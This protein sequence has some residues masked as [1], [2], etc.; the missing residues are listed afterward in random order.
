MPS[1]NPPPAEPPQASTSS[2]ARAHLRWIIPAAVAAAG[3]VVAG[4]V[5]GVLASSPG[6]RPKPTSAVS[7]QPAVKGSFPG[8][9]VKTVSI[10]LE[11]LSRPLRDQ[12]HQD[13]PML[14]TVTGFEFHTALNPAKCLT[15]DDTGSLAGQE[16]DPV[17]TDTCE[18]TPNQIWIPEQWETLGQPYTHLVSDKYQGMCLNVRKIGGAPVGPGSAVMLWKCYYPAGNESW[19]FPSWFQNVEAGHHSYPLFLANKSK[20]RLC[21]DADSYPDVPAGIRLWTQQAAAGQF[22]F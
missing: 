3:V 7:T 10:P 4:V 5:A 17:A 2:A 6:W 15:A 1:G 12:V 19:F 8:G 16:R 22:W 9:G 14:K 18:S 20:E 21:L 11:S 13:N